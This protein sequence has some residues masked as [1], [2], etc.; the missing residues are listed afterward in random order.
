VEPVKPTQGAIG[1]VKT[2]VEKKTP[3]RKQELI[4]LID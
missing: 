3:K 1:L 2:L 4:Q